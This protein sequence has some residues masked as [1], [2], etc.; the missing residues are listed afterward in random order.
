MDHFTPVDTLDVS[1][2]FRSVI[3]PSNS[4]AL[5]WVMP[6]TGFENNGQL[7]T[8]PG[9]DKEFGL[10][11]TV[12]ASG[13]IGSNGAANGYTSLNATLW[14]DPKNDAGTPSATE[15]DG[16]TFSNGMANDIVLATGSM[17]SASMFID[18]TT[19]TRHADY[20]ESMTPT[21]AGTL[22]L[23]GSIAPGSQLEEQLTTPADV[24]QAI[25]QPDGGTIDLVNGGSAV[26]TLDPQG[27][28]LV[29]NIS[30]AHLHLA[31]VPR[32]IH[33]DHDGHRGGDGRGR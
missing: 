17:V 31:D 16:A 32:F 14:A 21:L 24:F 9:F 18:P 2:Y 30:H 7:V 4:F 27:T 1:T 25:P 22:L 28:I 15:T 12:D 11:L 23:D 6:V 13:A 26:V 8:P 5:H 33:G 3:Q 10:Y 29:P 19:L 20:V